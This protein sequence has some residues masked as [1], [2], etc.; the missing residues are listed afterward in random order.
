M[1]EEGQPQDYLSSVAKRRFLGWCRKRAM[2]LYAQA[3]TG[4]LGSP[5]PVEPVLPEQIQELVES[6]LGECTLSIS[7]AEGENTNA[8]WY[9]VS[10]NV[11]FISLEGHN[12]EDSY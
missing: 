2:P 12:Q 3:P 4:T 8:G 11:S 1:D 6:V 7:A 9:L 10:K 5:R